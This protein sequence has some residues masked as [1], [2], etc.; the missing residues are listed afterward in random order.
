MAQADY[1]IANQSAPN[2]RSEM[3]E[4]FNA[5]ATNNSGATEPTTTFPYQ[6]WY[7][8]STNLLKIRNADDDAWIALFLFNQ[9]TDTWSFQSLDVIDGI[10]FDGGSDYL[11]T[12]EKGTFSPE[13]SPQIGSYTSIT[14]NE[15]NG[16]YTKI[17]NVVFFNIYIIINA[18]NTTGGSG[19]LEIDGL[20]FTSDNTDGDFAIITTRLTG[21]D[22]PANSIGVVGRVSKNTTRF[23]FYSNED[24]GVGPVVD[25]TAIA[26]SDNFF[27]SGFYFSS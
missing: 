27:C 24:D 19:S 16:K 9:T 14:Y 4:I 5:I 22:I 23:R 12:Y 20:P 3:N 18:V 8:S 21:V 17:G 26:A 10:S 13:V 7:D 6:W 2:V 15:Q 11:N 1:V 25:A